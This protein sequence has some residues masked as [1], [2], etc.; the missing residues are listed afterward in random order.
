MADAGSPERYSRPKLRAET[1]RVTAAARA[2]LF[3]V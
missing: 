2:S 1:T 3:R